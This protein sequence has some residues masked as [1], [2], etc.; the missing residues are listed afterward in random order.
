MGRIIIALWLIGAGHVF[1]RVQI[2]PQL[3]KHIQNFAVNESAAKACLE[4]K[5]SPEPTVGCVQAYRYMFDLCKKRPDLRIDRRYDKDSRHFLTDAC[6]YHDGL[7]DHIAELFDIDRDNCAPGFETPADGFKTVMQ[8]A[9]ILD[10]A[11]IYYYGVRSCTTYQTYIN[12]CTYIDGDLKNFMP[13]SYDK[14]PMLDFSSDAQVSKCKPKNKGENSTIASFNQD[15]AR[16]ARGGTTK[17][18]YETVITDYR[19]RK[20]AG[21]LTLS[22]CDDLRTSYRNLRCNFFEDERNK[23]RS[24]LEAEEDRRDARAAERRKNGSSGGGSSN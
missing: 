2:Q 4:G 19:N 5:P 7:A 15:L 11:T 9:D 12:L 17:N 22:A 18:I 8:S 13:K 10:E 21:Q 24:V 3:I 14:L 16:L 20:R 1:A 23:P 6:A